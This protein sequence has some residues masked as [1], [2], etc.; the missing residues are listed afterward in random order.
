MAVL[1]GDITNHMPMQAS[2]VL[3]SSNIVP[4]S[5]I[6]VFKGTESTSLRSQAAAIA[7]MFPHVINNMIGIR[8]HLRPVTA[9][10]RRIKLETHLQSVH[11]PP[12]F[13]PQMNDEYEEVVVVCDGGV[14]HTIPNSPP[15]NKVSIAIISFQLVPSTH[16]SHFD[17]DC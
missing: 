1:A 8:I 17:F 4:P 7:Y 12:H 13:I 16:V 10:N 14:D 9:C 3:Y 5:W 2:F 11:V 6:H 15:R